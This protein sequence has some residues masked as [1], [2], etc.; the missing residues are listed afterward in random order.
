[1]L[2]WSKF[3]QINYIGE[4]V[5][6]GRFEGVGFLIGSLVGSFFSHLYALIGARLPRA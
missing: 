4:V 5:I 2:D 3:S 6:V 1:M